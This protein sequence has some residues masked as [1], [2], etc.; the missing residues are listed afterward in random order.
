MLCNQ[1]F[2]D[3]ASCDNSSRNCSNYARDQYL[4]HMNGR[5]T[6]KPRGSD[7]PVARLDTIDDS[8]PGTLDCY[9]GD[10]ECDSPPRPSA[11]AKKRGPPVVTSPETSAPLAKKVK[12]G[13]EQPDNADVDHFATNED[14]VKVWND[15][16]PDM[17]PDSHLKD[18]LACYL[19]WIHRRYPACSSPS[20]LKLVESIFGTRVGMIHLLEM[21][22]ITVNLSD[23]GIEVRAIDA[24]NSS[25]PLN[26]A[27]AS[28]PE[29]ILEK[30]LTP[31]SSVYWPC[32]IRARSLYPSLYVWTP[33]IIM[34]KPSKPCMVLPLI[35]RLRKEGHLPINQVEQ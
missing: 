34:E 20:S 25:P 29:I 9:S 27:P 21:N 26:L 22:G 3:H 18:R 14:L 8:T 7:G 6:A 10:D 5:P 30:F 33:S 23:A 17:H 13:S 16:W 15:P 19:S 4:A 1:L 2:C 31:P 28:E 24:E 32:V 11:P 12:R 35:I